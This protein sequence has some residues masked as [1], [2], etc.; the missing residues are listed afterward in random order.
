MLKKDVTA[1]YVSRSGESANFVL[2]FISLELQV[3]KKKL[4]KKLVMSA[5]LGSSTIH[6]KLQL[7]SSYEKK[8]RN[9]FFCEK[10]FIRN[11]GE[12]SAKYFN[13]CERHCIFEK[14]HEGQKYVSNIL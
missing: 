9:I 10:A 4:V 3:V 5:F 7:A 13:K 12:S 2:K 14:I 8:N 1:V 6:R 11:L